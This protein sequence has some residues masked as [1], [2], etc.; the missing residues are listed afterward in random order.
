MPVK[1]LKFSHHWN[2]NI[3]KKFYYKLIR[4]IKI[5][6]KNIGLT[7]KYLEVLLYN[8]FTNEWIWDYFAKLL[9]NIRIYFIWI[10]KFEE[11]SI[12]A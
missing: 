10:Q 1:E 9:S 3:K 7:A 5:P 4:K 8:V 12:D 2:T 6:I 11:V